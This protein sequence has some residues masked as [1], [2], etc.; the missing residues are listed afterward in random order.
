[1]QNIY[2]TIYYDSLT[3]LPNVQQFR[4]LTRQIIN[5]QSMRSQGMAFVY[6]DLKNSRGSEKGS[7]NSSDQVLEIVA[8]MIQ[9]TFQGRIAGRLSQ[10][11]FAVVTTNDSLPDRLEEI[12]ED[13]RALGRSIPFDLKAGIY[14]V[15]PSD[16]DADMC[17]D[18]AR[19]ACRSISD[20]ADVHFAY[21]DSKLDTQ[22]H[23]QSY[24]RRHLKSAMERRLIA[25]FYQPLADAA[26][27]KTCCYE[28]QARWEDPVYGNMGPD[29]YTDTLEEY[30]L[31]HEVDLFL[32][33]QVC[34]EC[35][36]ARGHGSKLLPV[37]VRISKTDFIL[38]DVVEE[39]EAILEEMN[40]PGTFLRIEISENALHGDK[41]GLIRS[42]MERFRQL[43]IEVWIDDFGGGYSSLLNLKDCPCDALK[44]DKS[45]LEGLKD[46][47]R[48]L[49][50]LSSVVRMADMLGLKTV[51]KGV[52]TKETADI[53]KG[54]GCDMEQG[55][56]FGQ[57]LSL[58]QLRLT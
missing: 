55:S 47:S 57:P 46:G 1:M 7:R 16:T 41:D 52:E 40:I 21:Y 8:Q 33:R 9:T 24:L 58:K 56:C 36:T 6:F 18:K 48:A 49:Q 3:R 30:H 26:S 23:M 17:L 31:I 42:A 53:L 29:E 20:K 5:S 34:E 28:A 14:V 13:I 37:A 10:D 54:T 15:D 2:D 19:V 51:V 44:L 4:I 39:V 22:S 12:S 25:P 27:G 32:I 45:F 11:H 38:A 50:V 35:N 43:G